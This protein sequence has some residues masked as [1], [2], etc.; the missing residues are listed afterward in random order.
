MF[1]TESLTPE[2]AFG[3]EY[4]EEQAR[5]LV[6]YSGMDRDV[7][8]EI[9]EDWSQTN[10]YG[11]GDGPEESLALE[12]LRFN[13]FVDGEIDL[14]GLNSRLA[15][16]IS[17]SMLDDVEQTYYDNPLEVISFTPAGA[18]RTYRLVGNED[19]GYS[20]HG[21]DYIQR[22]NAPSRGVMDDYI[23]SRGIYSRD[24]AEVILRTAAE[25]MGD[26]SFGDGE[27]KWSDQ[28]VPGGTNYTEYRFQLDPDEKEL[29]RNRRIL[30]TTLTIFFT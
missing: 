19:W 9:F 17:A 7:F 23:P 26:F 16:K 22:Q 1:E 3:E 13:Q 11:V 15:D 24:E 5:E 28:T 18:Q 14:D 20:S 30:K 6:N 21:E 8:S 29:F 12:S 25:D 4:L 10:P 2:E 27:T